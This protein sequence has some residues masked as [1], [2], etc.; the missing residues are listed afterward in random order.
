M[1]KILL[2]LFLLP[3]ISNA[4]VIRAD[5]TQINFG[6]VFVGDRD[7]VQITLN[8]QSA[9]SLNV[10]N[11]KFYTIYNETPFSASENTFMIKS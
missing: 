6:N 11:I 7:S 4:Q 10:T 5:S 2:F 1:K 8:N 3:L 9:S